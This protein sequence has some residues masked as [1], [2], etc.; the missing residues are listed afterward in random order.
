MFVVGYATTK[1][2]AD[3]EAKEFEVEDVPARCVAPDG[4]GTEEG[5]LLTKPKP[6]PSGTRAIAVFLDATLHE[7]LMRLKAAEASEFPQVTEGSIWERRDT[8]LEVKVTKVEPDVSWEGGGMTGSC[9]A[10]YWH[11]RFKFVRY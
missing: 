4:S 7:A 8:K 6:G 5:Y 2:I 11:H 1:E 3:L 9:S 10:F